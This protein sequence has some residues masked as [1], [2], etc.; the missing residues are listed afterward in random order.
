MLRDWLAS[1]SSTEQHL[2]FKLVSHSP[3]SVQDKICRQSISMFYELLKYPFCRIYNR[4]SARYLLM[5]HTCSLQKTFTQINTQKNKLNSNLSYFTAFIHL[6]Y[7]DFIVQIVL[8]N[9][10]FISVPATLLVDWKTLK[11]QSFK[12][13][14]TS[15]MKCPPNMLMEGKKKEINMSK[16]FLATVQQPAVVLRQC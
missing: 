3:R 10:I 4:L 13:N 16:L 1:R 9:I 15:L 8:A 12:G 6:S 2:L 7:V 14:G 11:A 5:K